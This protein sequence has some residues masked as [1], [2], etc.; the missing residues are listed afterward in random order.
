MNT[1][2]DNFQEVQQT[3]RMGLETREDK[4]Q[5]N[6]PSRSRLEVVYVEFKDN[7]GVG[8]SPK[9]RDMTTS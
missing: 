2:R 3:M 4:M 9:R 6:W 8:K 7:N 5:E 1:N